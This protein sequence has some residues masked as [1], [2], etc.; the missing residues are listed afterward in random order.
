VV[1]FFL[2]LL[3]L[4]LLPVPLFLLAVIL[5]RVAVVLSTLLRNEV[6]GFLR[7]RLLQWLPPVRP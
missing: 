4:L 3:F 5:F 7:Y 2:F 6:I 1:Q